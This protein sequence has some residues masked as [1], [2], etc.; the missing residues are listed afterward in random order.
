MIK[1]ITVFNKLT[2]HPDAGK[3]ILRLTF[4]IL[5]MFHG[6]AKIL[7]GTQWISAI[8]EAKGI[9]A[10]IAYG[11]FAGEIIAPIFIILG[12]LTRPAALIYAFNIVIATLL[13]GMERFLTVTKV[14]AW[15]LETEALFF[16]GALSIMLIGAGKYSITSDS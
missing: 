3:L 1:S 7:H 10:F 9:P 14:G 13:V 5:V 6:V 11:V 2:D 15:G 16:F 4:G 8:L 12:F